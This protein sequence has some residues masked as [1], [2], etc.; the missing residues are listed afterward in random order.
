MILELPDTLD[1]T[2][3]AKQLAGLGLAIDDRVYVDG[4]RRTVPIRC[5]VAGC[6]SR[7]DIRAG[8]RFI[9]ATHELARIRAA[10]L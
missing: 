9:C 1:L 2:D 4:I 7:A 8:G 6:Q 5:E 3:V 10:G